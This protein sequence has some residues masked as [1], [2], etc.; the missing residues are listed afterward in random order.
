MLV[1][2]HAEGASIMA[3]APD[4]FACLQSA[5]LDDQITRAA[6]LQVSSSFFMTMTKQMSCCVCL[7]R[8]KG[9]PKIQRIC[10]VLVAIAERLQ[11]FSCQHLNF[12]CGN[13][14]DEV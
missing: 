7:R 6:V 9:W 12:S 14:M 1:G 11:N 13:C 5:V 8:G 3:S 4:L 10:K 2:V